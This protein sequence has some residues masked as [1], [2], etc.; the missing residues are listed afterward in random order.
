MLT[1]LVIGIIAGWIAGK[2]MNVQKK[3]FL[4][5]IVIGI[6]G[7]FVGSGVMSLLGFSAYGFIANILESVLGACIFL[8]IAKKVFK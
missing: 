6:I 7:S 3:G 5:T 4:R 8:F 2:I 1:S